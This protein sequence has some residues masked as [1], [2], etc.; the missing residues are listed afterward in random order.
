MRKPDPRMLLR[1][2]LAGLPGA[3]GSVPDGMA[4]SLLAGVNPIHGL[5]ASMA[6]PIVGGLF[7]STSLVVVT[8]TSAAALAA[9]STLGG[10]APADKPN[11][12]FLLTV[13]AGGFMVLAGISA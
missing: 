3:I 2:G 1:E 8:T 10:M 12:L 11:A 9:G 7:A 5:Y 4:A 6:G 13:L